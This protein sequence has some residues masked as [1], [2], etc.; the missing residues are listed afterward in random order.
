MLTLKSHL[1]VSAPRP[2]QAVW[3]VAL[4]SAWSLH[5]WGVSPC[6]P[7]GFGSSGSTRWRRNWSSTSSWSRAFRCRSVISIFLPSSPGPTKLTAER[8][9]GSTPVLG[10]GGVNE[11][12]GSE[13]A[14]AK[15][16]ETQLPVSPRPQPPSC[17]GEGL[18]DSKNFDRGNVETCWYKVLSGRFFLFL[19]LF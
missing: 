10:T 15:G 13:G 2:P 5:S 6:A 1:P 4:R 8:Y 19:Y 9:Y 3:W 18:G 7:S 14:R 12:E 16:A 17:F 11:E